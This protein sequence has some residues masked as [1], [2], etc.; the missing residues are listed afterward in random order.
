MRVGE[1]ELDACDD[2]SEN[3]L[4]VVPVGDEFA[5]AE[6]VVVLEETGG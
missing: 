2:S 1:A 3:P 6:L 4:L 5:I